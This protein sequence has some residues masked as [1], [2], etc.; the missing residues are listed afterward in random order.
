MRGLVADRK[1]ATA[2]AEYKSVTGAGLREC[3]LAVALVVAF[4]QATSAT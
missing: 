3:R 1:K 4:E 2:A